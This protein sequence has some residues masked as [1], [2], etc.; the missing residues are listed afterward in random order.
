M[1]EEHSTSVHHRHYY[2]SLCWP[3]PN[4][5]TMTKKKLVGLV[6]GGGNGKGGA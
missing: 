3:N 6:E 1:V 2:P 4:Q 5:Q